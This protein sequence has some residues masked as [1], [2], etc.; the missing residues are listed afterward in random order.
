MEKAAYR[1]LLAITA[2]ARRRPD[3][4]LEQTRR[5]GFPVLIKAVAGGGGKG[6]RRVDRAEDFAA[7]AGRLSARA[8]SS[9]GDDRVLVEK[10]VSPARHIEV[11]SSA[12][13]TATRSN[14]FEARLLGAAASP[15][16]HR[17]SSGARHDGGAAPPDG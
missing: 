11:R 16:G 2:I 8:Q 4:L 15:E 9:F 17:G 7:G 10:Y 6:M 3:Y 1:S 5:I 14:L 12:T 13:C